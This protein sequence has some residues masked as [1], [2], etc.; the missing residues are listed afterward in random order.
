MQE[1]PVVIGYSS[2]PTWHSLISYIATAGIVF[3]LSLYLQYIKGL[4]PQQA[5]L[6]LVE[7]PV[8]QAILSPITGKLSDKTGS[9]LLSAAGMAIIFIGLLAFSLMDEGTS[10]ILI[11]IILILIGAGFGLFSSPNVNAVMT[12]ITPKYY[13]VASSMITTVRTI[14]QTLSM[15]I[16]TIVIAII[17]GRVV[18]TS[19]SY[20]AFL[21]SFKII[22]GIFAVFCFG[23]ILASLVRG[24]KE[25]NH[26]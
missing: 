22:F 2:L 20:P 16:A 18:I 8:L 9:R 3:L 12:S 5:G 11:V 24:K 7:Q 21:T 1:A 19:E 15:G 26:K 10:L 23:G 14:G 6:I 13:G 17:I 25:G 4:S